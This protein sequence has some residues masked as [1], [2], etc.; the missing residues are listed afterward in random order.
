M[1][2]NQTIN[3]AKDNLPTPCHLKRR[4]QIDTGIEHTRHN[5]NQN[6]WKTYS[7][8]RTDNVTPTYC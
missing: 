4:V 5:M 6:H 2:I 8:L 1:T 3:H 7:M